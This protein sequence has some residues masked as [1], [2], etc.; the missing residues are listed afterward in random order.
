MN[1]VQ[2]L[3]ENEIENSINMIN[4]THKSVQFEGLVALRKLISVDDNRKF[5][6]DIS[7]LNYLIL[8]PI[9]K[10]VDSGIVPKLLEIM[11]W[12]GESEFQVAWKNKIFHSNHK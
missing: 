2:D 5:S 10:V 12:E 7:F 9:Q 4:S 1:P 3:Q 11:A 8:A 6:S